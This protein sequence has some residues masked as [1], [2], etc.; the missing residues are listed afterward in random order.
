MYFYPLKVTHFISFRLQE[1]VNPENLA[2]ELERELLALKLH[3]A[4]SH[5]LLHHYQVS[6]FVVRSFANRHRLR[7]ID[8]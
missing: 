4:R 5:A 7:E 3:V 2:A 6:R 8:D 1:Y